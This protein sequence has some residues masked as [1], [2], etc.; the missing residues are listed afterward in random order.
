MVI[1]RVADALE[2]LAHSRV[3]LIFG[4]RHADLEGEFRLYNNRAFANQSQI[5][6]G[7]C[8]I[9]TGAP[10]T[11]QCIMNIYIYIYILYI[12]KSAKTKHIIKT[13]NQETIL[14]QLLVLH[15]HAFCPHHEREVVDHA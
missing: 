15:L 7:V 1:L 2:Q 3:V 14:L 8:S 6:S 4:V 13:T 9:L 12:K 10:K 11:K 5:F